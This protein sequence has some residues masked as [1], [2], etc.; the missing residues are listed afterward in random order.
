[1]TRNPQLSKKILLQTKKSCGSIH[2]VRCSDPRCWMARTQ[3]RTAAVQTMLCGPNRPHQRNPNVSRPKKTRNMKDQYC[4]P[5]KRTAAAQ[6]TMS[7]SRKKPQWQRINVAC[8]KKGCGNTKQCCAAPTGCG[9]KSP[10]SRGCKKRRD[11]KG[12][13]SR[14]PKKDRGNTKQCHMAQKAVPTKCK[15][16]TASK[17]GHDD[18]A[19]TLWTP[20]RALAMQNNVAAATNHQLAQPQ[21]GRDDKA[22]MPWGPKRVAAM[23]TTLLSTCRRVDCYFFHPENSKFFPTTCIPYKWP[24]TNTI[25]F[26]SPE[27]L[28]TCLILF[29]RKEKNLEFSGWKK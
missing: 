21:K 28:Y 27:R 20:K 1:M 12:S 13:M 22:G 7:C 24:E 2:N 23:M 17:K 3:K 9:N 5:Q 8:P 25:F 10:M 19:G 4:A 11:D 15:C 26:S 18:K 6:T 14:A 16:R 29:Q